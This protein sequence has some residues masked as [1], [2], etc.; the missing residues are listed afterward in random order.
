[1]GWA[2]AGQRCGAT[3]QGTLQGRELYREPSTA[4]VPDGGLR[5]L[6]GCLAPPTVPPPLGPAVGVGT[7][8][9]GGAPCMVWACAGQRCN[10]TGNP[11]GNPTTGN[12]MIYGGPSTAGVHDGGLK[13]LRGCLAPPTVLPPRGQQ[14]HCQGKHCAWGSRRHVVS[15]KVAIQADAEVQ[16]LGLEQ[17]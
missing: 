4:G 13:A 8:L 10:P 17:S 7:T 1:M 5:A 15:R 14:R 6:R 12:P 9:P 3:P 11:A 2:C 16:N